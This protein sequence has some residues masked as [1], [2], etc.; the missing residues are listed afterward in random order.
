MACG[1]PCGRK[2]V[3]GSRQSWWAILLVLMLAACAREPFRVRPT[4]DQPVSQNQAVTATEADYV[5]QARAI[6]DGNELV[7]RFDANHLTAG[8]LPVYVWLEARTAIPL[9]LSTFEFRLR[10]AAGRTWRRLSV[11]QSEQRLMKAYGVRIYS[12]DGYQTFRQRYAA[13]GF[14]TA[15]RL[16]SGTRAEGFLFFEIP[17]AWRHSLTGSDMWLEVRRRGPGAR[18]VTRIELPMSNVVTSAVSGQ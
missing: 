12:V 15:G 9:D 6:W 18:T 13:W 5:L 2:L 17:R 3:C 8:M 4:V 10:D 7:D 1:Q 16:A 14:P 11:G